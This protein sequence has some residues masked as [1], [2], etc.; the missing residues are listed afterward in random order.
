MAQHSPA[1]A[2]SA[3]EGSSQERLESWK[4]IAAYLKRAAR[5]VQRWERTAHLPVHRHASD[6]VGTV[7]AYKSELDAWA[8]NQRRRQRLQRWV[9]GF[10]AAVVVVSVGWAFWALRRPAISSRSGM[11]AR[12]V[13]AGAG[14]ELEGSPSP[15]GRYL[16][17]VDWETGD[18][19]LRDLAAGQSRRL[20]NKGSWADSNEFALSSRVSPDG[21]QIAYAWF[22]NDSYELRLISVNG[23]SASSPPRVLFRHPEAYYIVVSG[24]SADGRRILA[25]F[26]SRKDRTHRIVLVSASDGSVRV[27]KSLGWRTP[28]KLGLSPDSRYIVYD[29]PARETSPD[30][31]IFLLSVPSRAAEEPSETP[32]VQHPAEDYGPVWASDGSSILFASDRTGAVGLWSLAIAG[33]KPQGPPEL[34]KANMGRIVPLGFTRGGSYYYGLQSGMQDIYFADLDPATGQ[35]LRTPAR[36]T[37]RFLGAN[38]APAWSPD[39]QY[40]AYYSRRGPGTARPGALT[41][42]VHSVKDGKARDLAVNVYES[43]PIQWFPNGRSL[44]VSAKDNQ[45]RWSFY[46][47]D[48]QTGETKL[49]RQ[50]ATPGTLPHPALSPDGRTVFYLRNE[51]SPATSSILAYEI[52]RRREKK[53]YAVVAPQRLGSLAASRDGR[54]AFVLVDDSLT[55]GSSAVYVLPVAGG[56]AREVFRPRSADIHPQKGISWTPDGRHLLVARH[57]SLGRTEIWQVPTESGEAQKL[58]L[59]MDSVAFPTVHPTG[60]RLA[61]TGGKAEEKEVWVLENFLAGPRA[62]R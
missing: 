59:G 22:N 35:L 31:D 42:V 21:R 3:P 12:Q 41:L 52:E 32:L 36:A 4:E 23:E 37:E 5:T 53:L 9:W 15:D 45:N 57:I 25:L 28:E 27:L 30:R 44:L 2:S 10:A 48:A 40:L 62:A 55:T 49:L 50:S 46:R 16:S 20:T 13:W 17:F 54:L 61:F 1:A 14:V 29:S 43:N 58:E 56:E 8:N 11:A 18:L 38:L 7:F 60:R 51:R 34:V 19:A 24:W 33:G 39:G 6:K 47:V 26:Q